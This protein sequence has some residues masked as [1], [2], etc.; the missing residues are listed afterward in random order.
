MLSRSEALLGSAAL[1]TFSRV[2]VAVVGVG[3]VGGWCAEALVRTGFRRLVLVDDDVVQPSNL[4]RQCPATVPAIGRVK[5]EA[6]RERLLSIRPD[7]DIDARP[8]RF[9]ADSTIG[10]LAG[11]DL[12]VDAIDSVDCKAQLILEA[13]AAGVPLI[14]SMGAAGR[15]NPTRVSVRRFDAV[16]GDGLARA[17]RQRF[18][19]RACRPARP[20]WCVCS[21][22]PPRALSAGVKGS[23]MTVTAAFGLCLAA[24]TIRF[25]AD[26]AR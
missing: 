24:E 10:E 6:M 26:Q 15:T 12:I 8:T 23:L 14:S 13:T 5:V 7:A 18:K 22:E 1:E 17:L 16:A 3:G 2:R 4:N 20:F 19:K 25:F 21:D 9:R 11:C